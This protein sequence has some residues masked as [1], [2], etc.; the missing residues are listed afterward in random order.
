MR[1]TARGS[2][3]ETTPKKKRLIES[4]S[5]LFHRQGVEKTTLAEVADDAQVALGNV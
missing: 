4:A 3:A 1:K 2:M 5:R